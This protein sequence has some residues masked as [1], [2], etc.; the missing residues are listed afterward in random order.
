LPDGHAPNAVSQWGNSRR[1]TDRLRENRVP[2]GPL[3]SQVNFYFQDFYVYS[4]AQMLS[5]GD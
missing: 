2:V 3:P 5:W 1:G 4:M